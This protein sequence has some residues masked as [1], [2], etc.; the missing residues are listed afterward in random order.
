M[1]LS[2]E[3]LALGILFIFGLI[4]LLV[5]RASRRE[6]L[7]L[8]QQ[9][10]HLGFKALEA[11]PPELERRLAALYNPDRTREIRLWQFYHRR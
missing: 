11:A 3:L 9:L 2:P 4:I 10:R 6:N 1:S 5:V 8:E 7:E